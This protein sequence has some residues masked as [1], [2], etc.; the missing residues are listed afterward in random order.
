MKTKK[1]DP[2]DIHVGR[3]IREARVLKDLSQTALA[4]KVGITFQQLQKYEN[5]HNRVSCSRL[6]AIAQV[7]EV[8]VQAFFAGASDTMHQEP[9]FESFDVPVGIPLDLATAY[10]RLTP[11]LR[12]NL[13]KAAKALAELN[14]EER[15]AAQSKS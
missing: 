12:R 8:P 14:V 15:S 10:S 4:T 3:K 1:P 5:A 11:D 9:D 7:L 6:Y 2:V 13:S